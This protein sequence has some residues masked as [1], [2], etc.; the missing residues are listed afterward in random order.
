[1]YS[2]QHAQHGSGRN[3][4]VSG[5]VD[6]DDPVL[7]PEVPLPGVVG[8]EDHVGRVEQLLVALVLGAD[9]NAVLEL[10]SKGV[11]VLDVVQLGPGDVDHDD[12]LLVVHVGHVLDPALQLHSSVLQ[13]QM[14]G[15]SAL[16]LVA[17]AV[18][19]PEDVAVVGGAGEIVQHVLLPGAR[20]E[21]EITGLD[22]QLT[23]QLVEAA[24]ELD[25]GR[26]MVL[27]HSTDAAF[28]QRGDS[29][30]Q[31]AAVAL[32]A[33]GELPALERAG[34]VA[35]VAG[36]VLAAVVAGL[37]ARAAAGLEV[38]C[39]EPPLQRGEAD[40]AVKLGV[41]L[42]V[43]GAVGAALTLPADVALVVR[44][45]QV[46]GGERGVVQREA[47]RALGH[48]TLAAGGRYEVIRDTKWGGGNTRPPPHF[49]LIP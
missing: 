48:S 42:Q 38:G 28:L 33:G 17:N 41:A 3:L 23:L 47:P 31:V 6:L 18:G 46:S 25:E 1:M 40:G 49:V 35:L 24:V 4:P 19:D 13:D 36:V 15:Q 8:E 14:P 11:E 22:L 44:G 21:V 9:H 39:S 12:L 10:L 5:Q 7:A 32:A 34:V 16:A 2:A 37:V 27:D 45:G 26:S 29:F 30:L 20:D 43:D